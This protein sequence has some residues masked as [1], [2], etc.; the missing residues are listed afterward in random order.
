MEALTNRQGNYRVL[1]ILLFWTFLVVGA[2]FYIVPNQMINLFNL[3]A[4]KVGHFQATPPS[5]EKFFIDLAVAYMACVTAIAYL[6]Q[7]DVRKNLN[8]TPV[9]IVGKVTSSLISLVSFIAYQRSLLYFSNFL[10]DGSIVVIV[11]AFYLP[12]KNE[13]RE[14]TQHGA[15]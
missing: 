8:L 15:V 13:S 12:V 5:T 1:M 6:I 4:A 2:L 3:I 9:L 14:Q 11:L 10:I 7:K